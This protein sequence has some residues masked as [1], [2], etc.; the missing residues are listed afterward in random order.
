[1]VGEKGDELHRGCLGRTILMLNE[2]PTI[3]PVI[4]Y[5]PGEKTQGRSYLRSLAFVRPVQ[6]W[7]E[8]LQK[9]LERNMKEAMTDSH[10]L[11]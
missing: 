8:N 5:C 1:M 9:R 11:I 3:L 10:T 6:Q 2:A 4:Y 7:R